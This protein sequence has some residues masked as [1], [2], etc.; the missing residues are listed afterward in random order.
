MGQMW[1]RGGM[2]MRVIP[3]NNDREEPTENRAFDES[4]LLHIL[5]LTSTFCSHMKGKKLAR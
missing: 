1:S 5:L 3:F 4:H 2:Q